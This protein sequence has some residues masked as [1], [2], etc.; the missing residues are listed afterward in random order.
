MLSKQHAD[1]EGYRDWKTW[2]IQV[3]LAPQLH[4]VFITNMS[5]MILVSLFYFHQFST[6]HSGLLKTSE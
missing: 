6:R 4:N 3:N 5:Q 2:E 1:G